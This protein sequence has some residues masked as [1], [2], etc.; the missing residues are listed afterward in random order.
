MSFADPG[1]LASVGFCWGFSLVDF[2]PFVIED[3]SEQLYH[4]ELNL[5]SFAESR[6]GPLS[7]GNEVSF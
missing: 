5:G 4:T 6:A 3:C 7:P 1:L 2:G